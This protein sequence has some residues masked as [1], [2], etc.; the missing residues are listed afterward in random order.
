MMVNNLT[1]VFNFDC[2]LE[3]S[4]V[5]V[6]YGKGSSSSIKENR[7]SRSAHC[8]GS[9]F[10]CNLDGQESLAPAAAASVT[11]SNGLLES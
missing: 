10:E 4:F 7:T 8:T 11:A 3:D 6:N 9:Q 2:S 5:M 1:E